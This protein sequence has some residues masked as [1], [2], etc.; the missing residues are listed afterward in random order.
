MERPS[1]AQPF[2]HG[3]AF[4]WYAGI[5][6]G[7]LE[8]GN[9]MEGGLELNVGRGECSPIR[10]ILCLPHDGQ[11]GICMYYVYIYILLRQLAW[12]ALSPMFAGLCF[13]M[14]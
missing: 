10:K 9:G 6:D 4:H 3:I 2:V 8:K 1:Q 14:A 5:K 7:P 12:P 13:H 11:H